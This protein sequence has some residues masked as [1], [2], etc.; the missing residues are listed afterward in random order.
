MCIWFSQLYFFLCMMSDNQFKIFLGWGYMQEYP[1]CRAFTDGRVQQI[2][3][4]ANEIMKVIIYFN[5]SI[6]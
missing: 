4:G 5:S 2:Y 3:G 6:V 1:I